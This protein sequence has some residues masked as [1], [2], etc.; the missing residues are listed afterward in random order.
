MVTWTQKYSCAS[1]RRYCGSEDTS[2]TAIIRPVSPNS[3]L[4]NSGQLTLTV[5]SD[6]EGSLWRDPPNYW[7]QIV[8]PAYVRA[9]EHLFAGGDVE[10]GEINSK[11]DDLLV[12]PGEGYGDK[13]LEMGPMVE[14]TA[15][16][17]LS[18]SLP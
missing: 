16:R 3:L 6:P 14:A 18:A 15:K 10:N 11:Y 1:Q 17:I 7:E 2:D 5:Q 12:L 9:H 8:Y 4:R 13:H